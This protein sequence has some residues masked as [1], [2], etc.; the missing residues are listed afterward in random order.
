MNDKNNDQ[1]RRMSDNTGVVADDIPSVNSNS[2]QTQL[3]GQSEALPNNDVDDCQ[4]NN[5]E[6]DDDTGTPTNPFQPKEM[7]EEGLALEYDVAICGT[8]L[9]QAILASALA[10][11]G[12][13]ILHCDGADYYG[14]LDTVWTLPLVEELLEK[15]P[16][17]A[18]KNTSEKIEYSMYGDDCI[19][20]EPDGGRCSMRWHHDFCSSSL[21]SKSGPFLSGIRTGTSVKTPFG[22]GLVRSI[23]SP[24]HT[25][26]DNED[27]TTTSQI[28]VEIVLDKWNLADGRS[29]VLFVSCDASELKET[30]GTSSTGYDFDPLIL[31]DKLYR[32]RNIR[33]IKS[34]QT[35]MIVKQSARSLALDATPSFILAAGRAVKGMLASGVS[36]YLEFKTVDGLYWLEKDKP[37]TSKTKNKK[38]TK[39]E[40]KTE[41]KEDDETLS[42]FRVPCS[43]NDVFGTKLLAPMEKRRFMKF[44]Q[45]SMD[46]ATK[47]AVEEEIRQE[48]GDGGDEETADVESEEEVHSLNE[49][50]LNQG[51]S[52]ARPQN[53]TVNKS[54]LQMLEEAMENESM[55]F[56]EFLSQKYKLS[57]KLRSI[58][59][60]A[61]AWEI[62]D[63]NTTLAAGMSTLRKHLQALG[64]YGTTAFLVPLYGSGE[65]SQ[66]FCRSAAVFGA[67]YLL[68][69]APLAIQVDE[70]DNE[71]KKGRVKGIVL[72]NDIMSNVEQNKED[73]QQQPKQAT[74]SIKCSHVILPV[75]AL[76]TKYCQRNDHVTNGMQKRII[77]RISVFCGNIIQSDTGEQRHIIFIPPHTIGNEHAIH[78]ILL[79]SS[80]NVAP[81]GCTILHLTTTIL[82]NQAGENNTYAA[83]ILERAQAAVLRSKQ[84]TEKSDDP[85]TEIY[86]VSFSHGFRDLEEARMAFNQTTT[87]FHLCSHTAQVL[88]ADSAFEQAEKIFQSICP[89][90]K[91]L[92]LSSEIDKAIRERVEEK[93]YDDDE[94]N[95]LE[96]AMDMIEQ[97][98]DEAG[99]SN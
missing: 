44:I 42:L 21:S 33:S 41:G 27:T 11:A 29:P 67:T 36:D 31:E 48:K 19:P 22:D 58:V 10:R 43:K 98:P 68:R 38:T 83:E 53:K 17:D 89:G 60:Y 6:Q 25:D 7:D 66:A 62:G 73:L 80:A 77:R 37:A 15:N 12:K 13:S 23:R 30:D 91:F 97:T 90:E 47:V 63:S 18:T 5:T 64:R 94:K 87:G 4:V 55:S 16:N 51:R 84:A 52:L 1:K 74:K 54:E 28:T 32:S 46:Y 79:D 39:P 65:L 2:L 3:E 93:R 9:V 26:T 24:S 40:N 69:R 57:P 76:H 96:S 8:G 45:L 71:S 86:H 72:S 56:D 75:N 99:S 59:R 78:G 61:L 82:E 70:V 92:G 95:V 14:E 20:L 34:I 85:P 49:R 88:T 35:E 50:H 81:W